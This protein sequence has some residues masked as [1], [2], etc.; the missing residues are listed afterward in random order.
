MRVTVAI[1]LIGAGLLLAGCGS[2]TVPGDAGA[3][4]TAVGEAAFSPCEDIPDQVLIDLGLD[5]ATESP[6]IMGIKQPGWKICKWQG[7]GPALGVAATNY[8]LGDV[9]ENARNTEFN[10]IEVSGRKGL[11]YRETTDRERRSC[12]VALATGG[13]VAIISVTYLGVDPV[14]EDP[15]LVAVRR[16][17]NIAQYI[18]A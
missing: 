6:E 14:V 2:G 5:P 10:E 12:D 1:V 8:T 15:C 11:T 16:A 17:D 18:P 9:R 7:A 4:G 3:E 13:G